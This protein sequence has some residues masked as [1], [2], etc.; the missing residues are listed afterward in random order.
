MRCALVDGAIF[1]QKSFLTVEGLCEVRL[2]GNDDIGFCDL[3]MSNGVGHREV[4]RALRAN[5]V[6]GLSRR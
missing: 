3:E 5:A 2:D 4:S 6:A 1:R